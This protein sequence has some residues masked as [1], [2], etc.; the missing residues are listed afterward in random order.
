MLRL[1]QQ[2]LWASLPCIEPP[3][4]AVIRQGLFHQV[5]H[6]L[7]DWSWKVERIMED[8]GGLLEPVQVCVTA[9]SCSLC[10]CHQAGYVCKQR[11]LFLES[12]G[13]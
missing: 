4:F 7:W 5:S 8:D 10:T 6:L 12:L 3:G 1:K 11:C 2:S 9:T 13:L